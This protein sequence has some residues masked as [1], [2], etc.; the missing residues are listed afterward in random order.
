MAPRWYRRLWRTLHEPR[1]ITALMVGVYL[2]LGVMAV[3]VVVDHHEPEDALRVVGCVIVVVG[4]LVGAPSAWRGAWWSET[5]AALLCVL[6]LVILGVQE[7]SQAAHGDMPAYSAAR[8][9]VIAI[10]IIQR[11]LQIWDRDYAPWTGRDPTDRAIAR[12]SI[13]EQ[14]MHRAE[15]AA[16]R[17]Q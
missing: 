9:L 14:E 1:V 12:A 3:Q 11:C 5:P 4:V 13:A 7:A 16:G 2:V 17:D 15:Q 8:T 6:G 10:L